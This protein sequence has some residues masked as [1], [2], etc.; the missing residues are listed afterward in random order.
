MLA[1][2]VLVLV[3]KRILTNCLFEPIMY[4]TKRKLVQSVFFFGFQDF[5]SFFFFF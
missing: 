3:S 4:E 2:S 5:Y 1:R